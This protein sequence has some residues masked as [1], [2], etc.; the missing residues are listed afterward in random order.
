MQ[1]QINTTAWLW[2]GH[3]CLKGRLCLREKTLL[4]RL[5]HFFS[6]HLSLTIPL[7]EIENIEKVLVLEFHSYAMLVTSSAGKKDLF[8]M[9]KVELN[10]K[11]L[12]KKAQ[13]W[14]DNHSPSL[15]PR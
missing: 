5:Q 8:I 1:H 12:A 14:Q 4:F 9:K 7:S 2:N 6:S 10:I 13:E 3:Q 15:N 11:N